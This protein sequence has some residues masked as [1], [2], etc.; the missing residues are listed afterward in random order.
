ME[1]ESARA[2]I[3][4]A[5]AM[6]PTLVAGEMIKAPIT[7]EKVRERISKIFFTHFFLKAGYFSP[8]FYFPF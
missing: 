8:L 1:T 6:A 5:A 3:V 7:P 4:P 2:E